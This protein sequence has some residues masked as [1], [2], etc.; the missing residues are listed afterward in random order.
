MKTLRSVRELRCG[1][2]VQ[3]VACGE[4]QGFIRQGVRRRKG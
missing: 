3:A 4:G 2:A 1:V